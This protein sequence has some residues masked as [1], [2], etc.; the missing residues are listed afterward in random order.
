MSVPKIFYQSWECKLPERIEAQN[1]KYLPKDVE[2]KLYSLKDMYEYLFKNWGINY[3]NLFNSY[4]KI[5]HKVDLWRYCILYETGGYYLDAD[6]VL[7]NKLDLL[8]HFDMIFVTNNRGVQNI[9]NG[10]L[11]TPPN[12]P[13]FRSI[14]NNMCLVGNNFNNDYYFNCS[15][16]YTILNKNIN[17]NLNQQVYKINNKSLCLLIDSQIPYLM[18]NNDW[19]ERGRFGAFYNN[20]L[21]FIETNKYYPYLKS[22]IN[23]L[24]LTLK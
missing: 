5:P 3:A 13:I 6:C 11:K 9:F 24:P 20:I 19:I 8:D 16:L 14:I 2:Y 21:F 12:N 15:M 10:F 22:N 1:K 4:E 18:L 17:I 23:S 7:I